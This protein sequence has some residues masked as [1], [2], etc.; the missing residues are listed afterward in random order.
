VPEE[1][2]RQYF[3]S[4][5]PNQ[6]LVFFVSILIISFFILKAFV[7][8]ITLNCIFSFMISGIIN[9]YFFQGPFPQKCHTCKEPVETHYKTHIESIIVEQGYIYIAK[10]LNEKYS[11]YLKIGLTRKAPQERIWYAKEESTFLYSEAK[12]V[13]KY[14]VEDVHLIEFLL[15]DKLKEKREEIAIGNTVAKEWFKGATVDEIESS[16]YELLTSVNAG[17]YS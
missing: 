9:E 7:E 10:S 4:R 15:H 3:S 17:I 2:T 1:D 11:N 14:K 6:S 5:L 13:K 16:L 8:N 12:I